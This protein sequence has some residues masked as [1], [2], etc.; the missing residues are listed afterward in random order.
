MVGVEP[1]LPPVRRRGQAREP[2][3]VAQTLERP[4]H[5]G[6]KC[7]R[8]ETWDRREKEPSSARPGLT[9]VHSVSMQAVNFCSPLAQDVA[10]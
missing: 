8:C 2:L 3:Q 7:K 4:H 10:P 6:E 1:F 5:P 9:T